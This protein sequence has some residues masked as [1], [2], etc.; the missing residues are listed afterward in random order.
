MRN[1]CSPTPCLLPFLSVLLPGPPPAPPHYTPHSQCLHH[2]AP[3]SLC[4]PVPIQSPPQ[5]GVRFRTRLRAGEICDSVPLGPLSPQEPGLPKSCPL[6]SGHDPT[7][8]LWVTRA[9]S[10]MLSL[11]LPWEKGPWEHDGA[12]TAPYT[13]ARIQDIRMWG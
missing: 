3:G 2:R 4:S 5:T 9:H 8:T 7:M 10:G 12:G 13:H 1:T 11:D 6:F